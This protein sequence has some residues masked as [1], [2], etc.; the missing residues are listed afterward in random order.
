MHA[1]CH[2]HLA[3]QHGLGC[4]VAIAI[5]AL[6]TIRGGEERVHAQLLC[7]TMDRLFLAVI[8]SA[9]LLLLTSASLLIYRTGTP[10]GE[11]AETAKR[12]TTVGVKR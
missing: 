12:L 7:T 10:S 4:C 11:I 1:T 5:A 8:T 2:R 3:K 9:L 6:A